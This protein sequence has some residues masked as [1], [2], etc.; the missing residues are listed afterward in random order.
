MLEGWELCVED[1]LGLFQHDLSPRA[2][3]DTTKHQDIVNVIVLGILRDGIAKIHANGLVDLADLWLLRGILHA[4]LNQLQTFGVGLVCHGV[5]LRMFRPHVARHVHPTFHSQPRCSTLAQVHVRDATVRGP[6]VIRCVRIQIQ[7]NVAELIDPAGEVTVNV[8]IATALAA[9]HGDAHEIALLHHHHACQCGDLTVVDNLQRHVTKLFG[10]VAEDGN[11]PLLVQVR[12]NVGKDVAPRCLV[13]R[14][15]RAGGTAANGINLRQI[16]GRL[17]HGL[18]DLVPM[19]LRIWVGDVPLSLLARDH[20]VV[21][22]RH[23]LDVALAEVKGQAA[24]IGVGADHLRGVLGQWQI[25]GIRD[26]ED[27]ERLVRSATDLWHSHNLETELAL[28][29]EGLLQ[30]HTDVVRPAQVKPVCTTLPKHA[31]DEDASEMN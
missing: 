8:A 24:A 21:L 13:V 22:H 1:F 4:S 9:A 15:D 6:R 7:L 19:I 31:L 2:A 30:L 11:N 5:H 10:K 17:T 16:L 12:G 25:L 29:R 23:R 26:N 27:F 14:G 20:L 18:E 3:G 28:Q